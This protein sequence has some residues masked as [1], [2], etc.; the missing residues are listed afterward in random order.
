[1]F[2]GVPIIPLFFVCAFF[3]LMSIY[4]DLKMFAFTVPSVLIMRAISKKDESIFRLLFLKMRF[5]SNPA[6]KKFYKVI[7]I[8]ASINLFPTKP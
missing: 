6:A 2:F 1:M 7:K 3:G 5:L 4:V 8:Q